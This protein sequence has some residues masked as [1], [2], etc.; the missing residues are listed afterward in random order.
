MLHLYE[1]V[2]LEGCRQRFDAVKTEQVN[3]SEVCEATDL[4]ACKANYRHTLSAKNALIEL[5][6]VLHDWTRS[7]LDVACL[8]NHWDTTTVAI[9]CDE[10][11]YITEDL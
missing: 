8:L 11:D 4:L 2:G 1:D 7:V 6:N 9:D 10:G 3:F 5:V